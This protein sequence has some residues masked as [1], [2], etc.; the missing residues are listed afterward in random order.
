MQEFYSHCVPKDQHDYEGDDRIDKNSKNEQIR[1]ICVVLRTG[2][3]K[4][5]ERDTGES[6]IDLS[7]R[8]PISYHHG[9]IVEL[10]EGCSYTRRE[11]GRMNAHQVIT[12]RSKVLLFALLASKFVS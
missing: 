8:K 6:C 4:H 9:N 10:E 11:L 2:Q 12:Y 5:F 3:Q 1:R 7:P